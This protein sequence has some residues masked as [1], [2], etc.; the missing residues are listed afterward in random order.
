MV[1][2]AAAVMGKVPARCVGVAI[3]LVASTALAQSFAAVALPS[4]SEEGPALE[5]RAQRV[6]GRLA[7]AHG[8][9]LAPPVPSA[10]AADVAAMLARADELSAQGRLDEAARVLDD[11]LESGAKVPHRYSSSRVFVG[12]HVTRARIALARGETERADA[13]FERLLRWDPSFALAPNEASPRLEN[14]L[15]AARARVGQAALRPIDVAEAC[16]LAE[17]VVAARLLAPG[18]YE[19]V[20]LERCRERARATV[21]PGDDDALLRALGA[22]AAPFTRRPVPEEPEPRPFYTRAWFWA[23]AAAVTVAATGVIVWQVTSEPEQV[24][25]VPHL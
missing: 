2:G 11:G 15:A 25:V 8:G 17:V 13:L 19:F 21:G 18:R 16:A 14:A 6:A 24:D 20:R 12:A 3:T 5:E 4:R 1:V 9:R 7:T 22:P 23:A 10:G